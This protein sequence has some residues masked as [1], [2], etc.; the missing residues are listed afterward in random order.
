[1]PTSYMIYIV[2]SCIYIFSFFCIYS[3]IVFIIVY[4][5]YYLLYL[6]IRS[7]MVQKK[8]G[9]EGNNIVSSLLL[10]HKENSMDYVLVS[11]YFFRFFVR[12]A[13]VRGALYTYIHIY[14]YI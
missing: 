10:Q 12:G 5:Y 6:L 11:L 2:S 7:N 14:I 9:E 3:I 13:L 1:M 8:E 4:I